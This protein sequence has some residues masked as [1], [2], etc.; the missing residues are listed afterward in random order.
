MGIEENMVQQKILDIN[1]RFV[2]GIRERVDWFE[3][4]EIPEEIEE[5]GVHWVISNLPN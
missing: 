2:G 5:L 3:R 4:Q 1:R